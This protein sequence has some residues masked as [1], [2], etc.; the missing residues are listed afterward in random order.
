VGA[1]C[2]ATSGA[3]AVAVSLFGSPRTVT[4][5]H[6][7]STTRRRTNHEKAKQ[8]VGWERSAR[9]CSSPTA[10]VARGAYGVPELVEYK[11]S[12]GINAA[13]FSTNFDNIADSIAVRGSGG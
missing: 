8:Q 3:T 11:R 10:F 13:V 1:S 9:R 12:D 7:Y 5:G 2:R 4:S 6:L